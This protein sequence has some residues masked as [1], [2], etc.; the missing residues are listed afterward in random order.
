VETKLSAVY[1]EIIQSL[2]ADIERDVE[3]IKY[4][5][6]INENRM[7]CHFH[8]KNGMILEGTAL[9][10]RG[11]DHAR[12]Q[13]NARKDALKLLIVI[14]QYMLA[15][16]LYVEAQCGCGEVGLKPSERG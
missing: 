3:V 1:N 6:V 7:Y 11:G 16:D 10:V 14:E 4:K 8:M 13:D 5:Y 9:A 2:K 15:D 12:A